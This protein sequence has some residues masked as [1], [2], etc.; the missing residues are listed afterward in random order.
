IDRPV[1]DGLRISDPHAQA[2]AARAESRRGRQ[3]KRGRAPQSRAMTTAAPSGAGDRG[4]AYVAEAGDR[5][6]PYVAVVSGS[7]VPASRTLALARHVGA[8]LA[9]DGAEVQYMDIRDLPAED[10]LRARPSSAEAKSACAVVQ[11]A[12]GVVFLTPVY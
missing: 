9:G 12:A 1:A 6:P 4:E 7:P 11:G 5:P 3:A 2:G 10:L 8:S